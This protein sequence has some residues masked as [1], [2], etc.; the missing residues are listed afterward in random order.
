MSE[1]SAGPPGDRQEQL[2]KTGPMQTAELWWR[3][4]KQRHA[5]LL[6]LDA[7][8]RFE[9]ACCGEK[10]VFDR[11]SLFD[12]NTRLEAFVKVD[13]AFN[14][15]VHLSHFDGAQDFT[16]EFWLKK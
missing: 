1:K 10:E 13:P 3:A 14:S 2:G 16:I 8:Y 15:V 4:K 6:E 9:C 7:D 12:L 11:M 5:K